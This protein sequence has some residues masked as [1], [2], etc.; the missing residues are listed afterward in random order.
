MKYKRFVERAMD[1]DIR[2][3]FGKSS[4]VSNLPEDL[5]VF[6]TQNNPIDVEVSYNGS[7]MQFVAK[8]ELDEIQEV[9][10]LP[11]NA[12]CFASINGDPIFIMDG[13]IYRSLPEK[14]M[15]EL[16]SDNFD[17]FIESI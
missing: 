17:D 8:E 12:Y 14:F 4:D 6:Y 3:R 9:Y 2:N 1:F 16:L 11:D 7:P 5:R 13:K 15:P 10:K